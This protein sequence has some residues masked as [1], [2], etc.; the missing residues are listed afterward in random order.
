M[1]FSETSDGIGLVNPSPPSGTA[2]Q[3][4]ESLAHH[5][6]PSKSSVPRTRHGPGADRGDVHAGCPAGVGDASWQVLICHATSSE[7]N[8]DVGTLVDMSSVDEENNP[9]LNGHGTH[10]GPVFPNKDESG[11][12]GDIIPPFEYEG[13]TFAGYN[14]TELGQAIYNGGKGCPEVQVT[15]PTPPSVSPP[16]CD[17]P[18]GLTVPPSTNAVTYTVAPAYAPVRP[19]HL[20]SRRPRARAT[21]SRTT[22]SA[23]HGS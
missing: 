8:P 17:A 12:W 16:T 3:G 6:D 20:S 2:L 7:S 18:G 4:V 15:F 21:C 14:W 13:V 23:R 19:A 5:V 11:N 9:T 10:L 1:I 22:R